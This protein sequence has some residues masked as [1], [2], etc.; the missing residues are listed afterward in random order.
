MQIIECRLLDFQCDIAELVTLISATNVFAQGATS[1]Q[2]ARREVAVTFDDL[3][4]TQG[5][6][7]QMKSITTRLL[8][9]I[10]S[11]KVSAIGFVNEGKLYV[12]DKLDA[13]R[14]ALLQMWLDAG[15]E[16]GN[17]TFSHDSPNSTPLAAYEEDV[18]R[19]ERITKMLLREKSM[20]LR[21]RLQTQRRYAM[22][23]DA[24][25]RNA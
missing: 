17:H 4:A 21:A 11:N 6:L 7:E 18:V 14:S 16:L 3:P 24:K 23:A 19:G 1:N 12:N 9:S 25:H 22:R 10:T 2:S 13:R 20:K 8:R 5:D 15:L